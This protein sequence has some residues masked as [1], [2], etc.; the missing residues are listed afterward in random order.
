[1]T[2][3]EWIKDCWFL[4]FVIIFV[5]LLLWY[6]SFCL[7][8]LF[9]IMFNRQSSC[10]CCCCCSVMDV[11]AVV[12]I[13]KFLIIKQW[14]NAF[15]HKAKDDKSTALFS[16]HKNIQS[17]GAFFRIIW[18]MLISSINGIAIKLYNNKGYLIKKL[19]LRSIQQ[20]L[21]RKSFCMLRR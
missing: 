20:N 11:A 7:K 15:E 12:G 19:H 8:Q 2:I 3:N 4:I 21:P 5:V 17:F 18:I 14:G 1:M 9:L 16:F 13:F 10:V 6:F